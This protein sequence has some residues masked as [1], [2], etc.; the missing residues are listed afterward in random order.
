VQRWVTPEEFAELHEEAL[1]IGFTGVM[2]GPLLRS[3]YRAGR[4]YREAMAHRRGG[5]ARG[6]ARHVDAA[7]SRQS[8]TVSS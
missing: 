3:S 2:S 4:L 5:D 8:Y 1:A 7:A 6:I